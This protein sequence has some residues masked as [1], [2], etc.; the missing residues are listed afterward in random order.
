MLFGDGPNPNGRRT[1]KRQTDLCA[2]VR[3]AYCLLH[4]RLPLVDGSTREA[5][6]EYWSSVAS[7]RPSLAKALV[8]AKNA[9]YDGLEEIFSTYL[10]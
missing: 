8:F 7:C 6:D 4:Q 9:N 1:P 2:F 3:T 10:W 5:V